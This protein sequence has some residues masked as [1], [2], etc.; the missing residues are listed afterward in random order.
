MLVGVSESAIKQW[1]A[2]PA[3]QQEV[4]RLRQ[5]TSQEISAPLLA[6]KKD[7]LA[8]ASEAVATLRE[9]LK[10]ED[11]RG[12]PKH[13]IRK[14]AA[15]LL[16]QYGFELERASSGGGEGSGSVAQA[17]AAVTLTITDERG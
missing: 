10:A 15:A 13:T 14:E 9:N 6:L 1:R 4:E 11:D 5:L 16:L 12:R 7:V 2:K 8:A 3:Y 17:G